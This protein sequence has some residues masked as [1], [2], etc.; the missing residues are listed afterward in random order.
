MVLYKIND[1]LNIL[2]KQYL[3]SFYLVNGQD[4]AVG[5]SANPW[6][7]LGMI[8]QTLIL[9]TIILNLF[10]V[11]SRKYFVNIWMI[12]ILNVSLVFKSFIL[13]HKLLWIFNLFLNQDSP[14]HIIFWHTTGTRIKLLTYYLKLITY[15]FKSTLI[16]KF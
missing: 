5:T 7:S 15:N 11:Q 1:F 16:L 3:F 4:S 14:K 2:I 6:D 10:N 8:N 12:I 13:I 9:H